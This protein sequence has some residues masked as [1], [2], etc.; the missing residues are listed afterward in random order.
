MA[1]EEKLTSNTIEGKAATVILFHHA[2]RNVVMDA[3]N[4]SAYLRDLHSVLSQ[5]ANNGHMNAS[6]YARKDQRKAIDSLYRMAKRQDAPVSLYVAQ[7]KNTDN[8]TVYI[9]YNIGEN[10]GQN[11][12]KDI[13]LMHAYER[14]KQ[15]KLMLCNEIIKIQGLTAN[16][17]PLEE[18]AV[19]AHFNG[20]AGY[21]KAK[22]ETFLDAV[23]KLEV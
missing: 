18:T 14:Q 15:M 16:D 13:N 17:I 19:V 22:K 23:R 9:V 21:K 5:L 12:A 3:I 10:R 4:D 1:K 2:N 20:G 6:F 8:Q 11:N 7:Y